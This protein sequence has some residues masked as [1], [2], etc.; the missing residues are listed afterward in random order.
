[1]HENSVS[2]DKISNFK[3][4]HRKKK[5][6]KQA[7]VSLPDMNLTILNN[8]IKVNS[9]IKHPTHKWNNKELGSQRVSATASIISLKV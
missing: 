6:K 2:T 3:H 5:K 8:P 7:L 9:L 1:M 4:G